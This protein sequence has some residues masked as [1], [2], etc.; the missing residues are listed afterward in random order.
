MSETERDDAPDILGS[1]R[2]LVQTQGWQLFKTHAKHEWGPEGFG[3]RMHEALSS[4]PKGPDRVYEL[5]AAAEQAEATL[6][7]INA[8]MAWPEEQIRQLSE[9]HQ[10]QSALGRLRRITR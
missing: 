3:R 7:A 10:P 5:A 6:R 8:I 2:E 9:T 1:L 4:I